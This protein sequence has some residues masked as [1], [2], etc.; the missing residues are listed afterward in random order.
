MHE[1]KAAIHNA[2]E[3]EAKWHINLTSPIGHHIKVKVCPSAATIC[4]YM[5]Q[6]LVNVNASPMKLGTDKAKGVLNF[7]V[8]YQEAKKLNCAEVQ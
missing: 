4:P 7:I 6:G 8:L 3:A 5:K 2:K 1:Y